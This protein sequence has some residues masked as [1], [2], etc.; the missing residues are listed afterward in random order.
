MSVAWA[1]TSQGSVTVR[2]AR[3]LRLALNLEKAISIGL[4][5]GLWG[6]SKRSSAPA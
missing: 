5:S 1:M 4:K 6:G 2:A 3:R